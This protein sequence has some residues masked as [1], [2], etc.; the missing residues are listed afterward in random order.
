MLGA[1]VVNCFRRPRV[2]TGRRAQLRRGA[3]TTTS[4]RW[5]SAVEEIPEVLAACG[6]KWRVNESSFGSGSGS[7]R[8]PPRAPGASAVHFQLR[9]PGYT[10]TYT[11]RAGES[12]VLATEP[13]ADWLIPEQ[14]PRLRARLAY[15]GG[16]CSIGPTNSALVT[17]VNGVSFSD[18]RALLPGDEFQIGSLVLTRLD[19]WR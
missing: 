6:N 1:E 15:I 3:R 4:M 16:A 11:L 13:P 9:G 5:R 7:G 19:E 12:V 14:T 10:V 2:R 17:T 18:A 8:P